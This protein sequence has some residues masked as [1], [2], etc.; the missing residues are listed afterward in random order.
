MEAVEEILN[1]EVINEEVVKH[2]KEKAGER[3]TV[4]FCST[5]AHAT[6]VLKN[7]PEVALMPC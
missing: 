7:F 4:V 5:V 6:A 1:T 3:Q 2:W